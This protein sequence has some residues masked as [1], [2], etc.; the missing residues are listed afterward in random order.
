METRTVPGNFS[1]DEKNDCWHSQKK[2]G[3]WWWWAPCARRRRITDSPTSQAAQEFNQMCGGTLPMWYWTI[4]SAP[5]LANFSSFLPFSNPC[6]ATL[7][8]RRS[9]CSQSKCRS[10]SRRNIGNF[11]EVEKEHPTSKSGYVER[12]HVFGSVDYMI[13]GASWAHPIGSPEW[14]WS[15]ARET[16]E[17]TI[18][19]YLERSGISRTKEESWELTDVEC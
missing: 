2:P 10:V 13:F 18:T 19:V 12:S 3:E 17:S 15:N 6:G 4:W 8:P 5:V 9:Q 11:T 7:K 14:D 1:W 16:T